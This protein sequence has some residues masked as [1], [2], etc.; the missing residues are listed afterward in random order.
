MIIDIENLPCFNK[1]LY[2]LSRGFW[3]LIIIY[4]DWTSKKCIIIWTTKEQSMTKN[5]MLML[6]G[7][8]F[9]LK[10]FHFFMSLWY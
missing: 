4:N 8:E 10:M 2:P 1:L 5:G 3:R 6:S 9:N 7:D